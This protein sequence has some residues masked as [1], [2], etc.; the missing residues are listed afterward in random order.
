MISEFAAE[1]SPTGKPVVSSRPP[2]LCPQDIID[3]SR[4]DGRSVLSAQRVVP[5]TMSGPR[6]HGRI[7][8]LTAESLL[9]GAQYFGELIASCLTK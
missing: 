4:G 3:A 6:L 9:D 2:E 7:E 1:W 8:R 5:S